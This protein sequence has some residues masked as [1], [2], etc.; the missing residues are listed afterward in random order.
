MVNFRA[1]QTSCRA[2]KKRPAAV[3]KIDPNEDPLVTEALEHIRRKN[4]GLCHECACVSN[5]AAIDQSLAKF[6]V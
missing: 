6:G 3:R 5:S 1:A 4:D 2:C